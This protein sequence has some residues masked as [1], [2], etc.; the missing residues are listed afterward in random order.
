MFAKLICLVS[1]AV[2]F[3]LAGSS[4]ALDIVW[5]A[6][7]ASSADD[8][9][10]LDGGGMGSQTRRNLGLPYEDADQDN[11]QIVGLRFLDLAVPK[12]ADVTNAYIEFV[13]DDTEKGSL[14]VSLVIAGE[15]S[16]DA[17]IITASTDYTL[18]PT[19]A[20]KSTWNPVNWTSE[21]QV[22]RTP[23]I[24]AVLQEIVNQNGW[25]S[26]NS[27][28]LIISDDPDN[29]SLGFRDA[30]SFDGTSSRAPL[31][32]IEFTGEFA[33]NPNPADKAVDV[34]LPLLQWTSNA[35]AKYY[36]V[37]F[38][39]QC[40]ELVQVNSNEW[41]HNVCFIDVN[42]G[43]EPG[44]TYYWRVDEVLENNE[45]V[46][47]VCWS[48]KTEEEPPLRAVE[49]RAWWTFDENAGPVAKDAVESRTGFIEGAL[50]ELDI[51]NPGPTS[52]ALR[53]DGIDDWVEI[54]DVGGLFNES[55]SVSCWINGGNE[56]GQVIVSQQNG[57]NWLMVS[58]SLGL[59]T[60]LTEPPLSSDASELF[61]VDWSH[62][63]IVWDANKQ[64]IALYMDAD[65]L[66]SRMAFQPLEDALYIGRPSDLS[67]G[68]FWNGV[69]DEVR[70]FDWALTA[71]E[72][73]TLVSRNL[74]V[75]T[76]KYSTGPSTWKHVRI[77]LNH[78]RA[79]A[80]VI[81]EDATDQQIT[82]Y[83]GSL[84]LGVVEIDRPNRIVRLELPNKISR[85]EA[86]KF[87]RE[88]RKLLDDSPFV[89]IGLA[90][91][92]GAAETSILVN[93]QLTVQ[94]APDASIDELIAD[95]WATEVRENA[96]PFNPDEYLLEVTAESEQ[97]ALAL[98]NE[99]INRNSS[100]ILYAVPN[101]A[102]V[103][104]YRGQLIQW[105]L[106][107][108]PNDADIDAPEA[109]DLIS[110]LLGENPDFYIQDVNIAVIDSSDDY[111]HEAFDNNRWVNAGERQA[112]DD[113]NDTDGNGWVDD[114]HGTD[115]GHNNGS[116]SEHGTAV[117]GCIGANGTSPEG[118]SGSCPISKLMFLQVNITTFDQHLAFDYA[119]AKGADVICC[120][121]GYKVQIDTPAD[122]NTA[123]QEAAKEGRPTHGPDPNRGCVIVFAMSN[124]ERNNCG[125]FPDISSLE[126]V[127]A[128]SG[129]TDQDQR[130]DEAG[131]GNCMEVLAPTS[132]GARSI[133][134]TDVTDANGYNNEN[135][136]AGCK[137][138]DNLDYTKCFGGTS[139]ACATTAG[140]AGLILS[141]DPSLKR[142][143]VQYLLQDTAVK[144]EDVNAEYSVIDGF[145]RGKNEKSTH[146]YGRINAY[147]AVRT[148]G[149]KTAVDVGG[150]DIFMR[151]N[152][153][154]WGNTERPSHV[155]VGPTRVPVSWWDSVD[156]KIDVPNSTSEFEP[157]PE[158]STA[159]DSFQ[160]KQP[161]A[162]VENRVY[163]RVRNRG[164]A[165][166][167]CVTVKLHT[168]TAG[169]NP[170]AFSLSSSD[171]QSLD[172]INENSNTVEIPYSGCSVA[173]TDQDH[174]R[175]VCFTFIP[176]RELNPFAADFHY[177]L[178][179]AE[180]LAVGECSREDPISY[181]LT[182]SQ[183]TGIIVP[184]DNNITMLSISWGQ[185]DDL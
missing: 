93:E 51:N 29:P 72:I 24:S 177:L 35:D 61:P 97:D 102:I 32:H 125:D 124:D 113:G 11:R 17:P 27:I 162:H 153:L 40:D 181:D 87:T 172:P 136:K 149:P 130:V 3:G 80:A 52:A 121:W 67:G 4:T 91:T 161:K 83:A 147:E 150:V 26:G 63:C 58:D 170:P 132:G 7:V 25:L 30:E 137:D 101:F 70:I 85:L 43:F 50:W 34:N 109:W 90:V 62:V 56:A 22:D 179:T 60:E 86:T 122:V 81:S 41:S 148:L 48:F 65:H 104:E 129:S 28:L 171:W 98:A 117:A 106:H 175:I 23:D 182:Q 116:S 14:P 111:G 157:K 1:F 141:M 103:P 176:E 114:I 88:A 16:P 12:G 145:S 139:A 168:C 173:G 89:E 33:T 180:S 127:I 126:H 184:S 18:K 138:V 152:Y 47:G 57:V 10:Q 76:D 119:R 71:E 156:I 112:P 163:V 146:G 55:F 144:I 42:V 38:G 140:V 107:D 37:Y 185:F 74:N 59:K 84:G 99:Y 158:T 92:P 77:D 94:L 53:F 66:G 46:P 134:T 36:R 78:D 15:L 108:D 82:E 120:S 31:L 143:Q 105:H 165:V 110:E 19:T 95:G 142:E 123:I 6:R 44:Q 154:D 135:P 169:V 133:V 164:P 5:E 115:F 166:A 39:M 49:P 8:W 68:T 45:I 64:E 174:A 54:Y 128:V 73:A 13:C 118:V 159:F 75:Q 69:I 131:F 151:D 178:A 183:D 79:L 100:I 167:K 9:A 2:V 20:A 155:P 96:N 21:G 160:S